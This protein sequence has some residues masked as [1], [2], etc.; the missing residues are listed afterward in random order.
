MKVTLTL[1]QNINTIIKDGQ[2]VENTEIYSHKVSVNFNPNA[3]MTFGQLVGALNYKFFKSTMSIRHSG[4]KGFSFNNPF[5]F[6]IE[7]DSKILCD[8]L[9]PNDEIETSESIKSMVRM[10]NSRDGQKRF[11][12]LMMGMLFTAFGEAYHFTNHADY[13]ETTYVSEDHEKSIRLFA[14]TPLSE[15]LD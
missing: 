13:S 7:A 4:N 12:K 1:S 5:H 8:T 15:I 3:Q 14:D 11:A 2:L 9:K 10:S 6:R